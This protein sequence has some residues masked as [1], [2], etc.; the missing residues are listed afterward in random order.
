LVLVEDQTD[1]ALDDGTGINA[2]P[3][4]KAGAITD[5]LRGIKQARIFIHAAREKP[6]TRYGAPCVIED[7][8]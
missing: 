3:A 2:I 6:E 7:L 8:V 1:I 4:G 5:N